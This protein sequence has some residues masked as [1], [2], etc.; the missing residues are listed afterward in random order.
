MKH[1]A[2]LLSLLCLC[3]TACRVDTPAYKLDVLQGR[4]R[5]ISSTDIRSDSL[6]IEVDNDSAVIVYAPAS[7][8][9]AAGQIKWRS[10][11][12]IASV[13]DFSVSDLSADSSRWGATIYMDENGD[14]APISFTIISNNYPNAPGGSQYWEKE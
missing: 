8:N 9:F 12:A 3:S 13:G 7:S 1:L 14:Q 10:L 6:L 11:N 5:R 4:W 2:L